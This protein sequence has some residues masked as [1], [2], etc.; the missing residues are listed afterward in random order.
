MAGSESGSEDEDEA[1]TRAALELRAEEERA[2]A[3]AH[4]LAREAAALQTVREALQ[5]REQTAQLLEEEAAALRVAA[6][7]AAERVVQEV[8]ASE[9]SIVEA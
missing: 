9:S 4:A 1:Q 3:A 5:D 7:Q 8:S 6:G 2:Q